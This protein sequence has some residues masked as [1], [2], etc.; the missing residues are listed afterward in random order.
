[1]SDFVVERLRA[2]AIAT[3]KLKELVEVIPV[4]TPIHALNSGMYEQACKL[5]GID[6][7]AFY[8]GVVELLPDPFVWF[9][10][11]SLDTGHGWRYCKHKLEL[12]SPDGS[13]TVSVMQYGTNES[14]EEIE[15]DWVPTQSYPECSYAY[16]CPKSYWDEHKHMMDNIRVS[17]VQKSHP[18]FKAACDMESHFEFKMTPSEMRHYLTGLGLIEVQSKWD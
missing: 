6:S 9:E 11:K 2:Y 8:R 14:G 7:T 16:I 17:H 10:D 15:D 4:D 5:L 3:N 13:I 1:M 12:Q 18:E